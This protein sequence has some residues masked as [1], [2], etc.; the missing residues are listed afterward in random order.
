[1]YTKIF[2]ITRTYISYMAYF[3]D[4]IRI[5]NDQVKRIRIRF[6][7][8]FFLI[9]NTSKMLPLCEADQPVKKQYEFKNGSRKCLYTVTVLYHPSIV[10]QL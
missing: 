5:R 9:H 6:R 2:Y 4:R 10:Y 3:K 8:K 7:T 1:M